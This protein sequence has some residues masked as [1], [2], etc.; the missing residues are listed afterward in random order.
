MPL[1]F[2]SY[3]K[4]EAETQPV[5]ELKKTQIPEDAIPAPVDIKP[6]LIPECDEKMEVA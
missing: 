2:L 3:S 1:N 4:P 6:V 5:D